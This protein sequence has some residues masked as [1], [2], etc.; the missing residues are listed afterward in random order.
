M[1]DRCRLEPVVLALQDTTA[2]NYASRPATSGLV[3]IGGGGSGV[4]GLKAHVGLAVNEAGRPLGV[5]ALDADYADR[6]EL[7]SERW[8][9]GLERPCARTRVVTVCD[10]EG[11]LWGLLDQARSQSAGLLVRVRR[12]SRR[13]V[14]LA[15]GG[16]RECLWAQLAEKTVQVVA[17]GGRRK[18]AGREV[19]LELWAA[20]VRL[21][22]R[23]PPADAG[24]RGGE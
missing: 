16:E 23:R 3:N 2:L 6:L 24:R 17:C 20:R 9:E 21:A 5:Y 7:E 15:G 4:Q 10:R 22:P 19:R 12:G 13:E 11:D 8:G 18:R 14:L 1:V